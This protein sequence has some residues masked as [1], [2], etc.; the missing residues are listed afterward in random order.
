MNRIL[1]IDDEEAIRS[2]LRRTLERAGEYLEM[3]K[4]LGASEVLAKPFETSVFLKTIE[5]LL[6]EAAAGG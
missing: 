5:L 4:T 1:V 2:L 3:A 6:A